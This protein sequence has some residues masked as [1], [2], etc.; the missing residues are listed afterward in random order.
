MSMYLKVCTLLPLLPLLL[1]SGGV[2]CDKL[3]IASPDDLISFSN[4]VDSGTTYPGTTVLL[5]S[6]L[7]FAGKTIES[8]GKGAENCFLGTFDGQGHT[9]SNLNMNSSATY[10]GLFGYSG[11]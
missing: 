4:A 5:D 2:L 3:R 6:D 7:D 10:V 11:V 1:G 9:I 8:I